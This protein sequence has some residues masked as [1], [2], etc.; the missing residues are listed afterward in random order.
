MGAVTSAVGLLE[1]L[2][3]YNK[4]DCGIFELG[5]KETAPV[6]SFLENSVYSFSPLAEQLGVSL[7]FVT[8]ANNGE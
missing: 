7:S 6:I 3:C 1:S 5:K 2:S 4:I 8:D